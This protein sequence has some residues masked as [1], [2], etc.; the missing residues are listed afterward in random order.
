[1]QRRD[2]FY[3]GSVFIDVLG[4][5]V[6]SALRNKEAIG[7]IENWK[8]PFDLLPAIIEND[9]SI[10]GHHKNIN[11]RYFE[12]VTGWQDFSG[13]V[14]AAQDPQSLEVEQVGNE[15][16]YYGWVYSMCRRYGGGAY[17]KIDPRSSAGESNR[18]FA[19]AG[20]HGTLASYAPIEILNKCSAL[21]VYN[22]DIILDAWARGI[23]T[24][25][26]AH[27]L[28]DWVPEDAAFRKHLINFLCF[29]CLIPFD[30]NEKCQDQLNKVFHLKNKSG[31]L[32]P[33]PEELSWGAKVMLG[34]TGK[35]VTKR[36]RS[37]KKPEEKSKELLT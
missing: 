32:F 30:I 5:G 21:Y 13:I 29:K 20:L 24:A 9:L 27:G 26:Y 1:M 25:Q 18:V 4:V 2:G 11:P 33:L 31:N 16:E 6:F 36:S 10:H 37:R 12:S 7:I 8:E 23:H 19:E 22:S 15:R 17:V 14:I 3:K 34:L 35:A 28:F